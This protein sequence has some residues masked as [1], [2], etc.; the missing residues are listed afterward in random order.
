M[1]DWKTDGASS[2]SNTMLANLNARRSLG[3]TD[4]VKV[5]TT[6][7]VFTD[8]HALSPWL[9]PEIS[10]RGT[11]CRGPSVLSDTAREQVC[12]RPGQ[13]SVKNT[14]EDRLLL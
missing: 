13:F 7:T 12:Y 10:T 5:T 14:P 6:G 1:N 9:W 11:D 8:P 2:Y 4:D 3:L